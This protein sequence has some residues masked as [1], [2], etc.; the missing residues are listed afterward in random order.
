[1]TMKF[2]LAA[3]S[4]LI[5]ALSLAASADDSGG[6]RERIYDTYCAAC[7]GEQLKSSSGGLT[8]DLRRLKS[9]EHARFVNSLFNG[10]SKM[11]PWT[12]SQRRERP[13]SGPSPHQRRAVSPGGKIVTV[14]LPSAWREY[15]PGWRVF[16]TPG[17]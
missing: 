15:S 16:R 11:P 8:F 10:K 6:N 1:M 5:L 12:S 9:D 4:V 13:R 3:F 7:P 17:P 14:R 2:L